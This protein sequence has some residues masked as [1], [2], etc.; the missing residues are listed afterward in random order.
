MESLLVL[1]FH[2]V[3]KRGESWLYVRSSV[4]WGSGLYCYKGYH[5]LTGSPCGK[6]GSRYPGQFN[7]YYVCLIEECRGSWVYTPIFACI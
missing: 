5:M 3:G 1:C 4:P 6:Y 7:D 2:A